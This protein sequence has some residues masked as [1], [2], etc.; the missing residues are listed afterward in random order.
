MKFMKIHELRFKNSFHINT[1]YFINKK[2][3]SF[4]ESFQFMNIHYS[5][6]V[7]L[8]YSLP[9]FLSIAPS[10]RRHSSPSLLVSFV[11][12]RDLGAKPYHELDP[13]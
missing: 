2:I 4:H 7:V 3:N 10:L 5:L 6:F 13:S 11:S 1:I 12:R 8:T 9:L